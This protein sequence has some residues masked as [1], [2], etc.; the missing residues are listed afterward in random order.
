M[1]KVGCCGFPVTRERYYKT[2][3]VVEVQSTFYDFVKVETLKKWRAEAPKD[4]EF[5]IKAFQFITH[6]A[7]SPTYKRAK[8]LTG[9]NLAKLGSFQDEELRSLIEMTK[10]KNGYVMFN[11]ITSLED[12]QRFKN[13]IT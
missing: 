3:S 4:F 9:L 6:S 12:A 7:T 13:L 11:N 5:V 8:N 2:F 10:G 1:I